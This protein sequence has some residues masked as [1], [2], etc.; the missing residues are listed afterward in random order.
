MKIYGLIGIK[1]KNM[2]LK[3]NFPPDFWNESIFKSEV[4]HSK[5]WQVFF[6]LLVVDWVF[7]NLGFELRKWKNGLALKRKLYKGFLLFY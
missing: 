3:L 6:S 7:W 2:F 4:N 5:E 1:V